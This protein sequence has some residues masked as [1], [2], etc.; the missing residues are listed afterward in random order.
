MSPNDVSPN[1]VSPNDVSP[2]G[3]PS[4]LYWDPIDPALRDCDYGR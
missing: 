4:E 3:V 2:R 1:D